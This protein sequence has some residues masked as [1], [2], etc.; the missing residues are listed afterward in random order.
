V[1]L[2]GGELQKVETG[3]MD[4]DLVEILNGIDQTTSIELPQK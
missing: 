1:L 3:L 2:K 4:Y